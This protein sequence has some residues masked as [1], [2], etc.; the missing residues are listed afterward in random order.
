MSQS[1][2]V[3]RRHALASAAALV[4]GSSLF[5]AD[6]NKAAA[7]QVEKHPWVDAHSHIWTTD[8]TKYPLRNNQ[9]TSGP[10]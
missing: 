7:M 3:S 5:L 6:S 1:G 8:L 10:I 9:A 2:Q 4:S